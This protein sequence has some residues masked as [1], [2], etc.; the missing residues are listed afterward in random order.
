MLTVTAVAG[1]CACR[2]GFYRVHLGGVA[3]GGSA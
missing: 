2:V 1:L 3:A